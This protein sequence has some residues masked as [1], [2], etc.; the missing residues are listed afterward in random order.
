MSGLGV[1][2]KGKL[3]SDRMSLLQTGL[4]SNIGVPLLYLWHLGSGARGRAPLAPSIGI[5]PQGFLNKVPSFASATA[6]HSFRH[7]VPRTK[8]TATEA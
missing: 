5:K 1:R 7:K 2:W 3:G 8:S 4:L 6:S